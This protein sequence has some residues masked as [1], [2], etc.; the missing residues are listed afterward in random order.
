VKNPCFVTLFQL[1]LSLSLPLSLDRKMP[2]RSL[3]LVRRAKADKH[4]TIQPTPH[5]TLQ[6]NALMMMSDA[7]IAYPGTETLALKLFNWYHAQS[8]FPSVYPFASRVRWLFR[9]GQ[10]LV[11]IPKRAKSTNTNC[12]GSSP[13]YCG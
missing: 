4:A 1:A 8:D 7:F 3:S 5:A 9:C 6:L 12:C 13:S 10:V 2:S 11:L